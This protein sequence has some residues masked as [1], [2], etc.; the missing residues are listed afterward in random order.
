VRP[1][2]VAAISLIAAVIGGV[3]ALALGE[4]TGWIGGTET[5]IVGSPPQ[6]EGGDPTRLVLEGAGEPLVS[7]DFNPARIYAAR[8]DGVVT[9]YALFSDQVQPSGASQGSGFVVS[10]DGLILTNSHVITSAGESQ[11]DDVVVARTVYVQ[12]R[13]GERVP[14]KVV[15]WDPFTD[16]AVVKVAR[17]AHSLKP[18]PLGDS[19]RVVVGAPVAAIGSPFGNHTSLSVGVVSATNRSISSLTSIYNVVDAIQTD[20]PINRG[21]SGGP[22]FDARGRVIGV[23]AQIRS[24][25]GTSEGVGFAIPINSAKRSLEQLVADGEVSYAYVGVKTTDL[26]PRAARRF[27]LGVAEGAIVTDVSAN[28]PAARAGLRGGTREVEFNG[29]SFSLGGD[30]IVAINGRPIRSA[31]DVV[32]YVTDALAPGDVAVFTVVRDRERRQIAVR[33]GERRLPPR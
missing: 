1:G 29:I 13:D 5:V 10:A 28:S 3:S 24:E 20:A 15:G 31:D 16:V 21:N 27:E 14:A 23:N 11:P 32:R 19:T 9:I 22:L 7:G 26:T 25:S 8:A 4:T 6:R 30:V 33:M 18:V 17:G 2:A 12:F